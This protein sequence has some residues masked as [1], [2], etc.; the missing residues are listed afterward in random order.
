M[1]HFDSFRRDSLFQQAHSGAF[2]AH[3]GDAKVFSE[4]RR[5]YWW[6]GMRGDVSR[7]SL[8]CV[9]RQ[10]VR[11]PLTPIPVAGPFDRVG[12]DIIR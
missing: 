11:V 9:T 6:Y 1:E 3:M 8:V 4:L 10:A 2:G 7:W 5:H 12:V